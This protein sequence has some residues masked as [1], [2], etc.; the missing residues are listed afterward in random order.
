MKCSANKRKLVEDPGSEDHH[1]PASGGF[2]NHPGPAA[3]GL[4]QAFVPNA[5]VHP[6]PFAHYGAPHVEQSDDIRGQRAGE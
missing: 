5:A 3:P 1:M 4:H 6:V 2:A